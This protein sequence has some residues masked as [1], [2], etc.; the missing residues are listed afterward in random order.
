MVLSM[1]AQAPHTLA[2]AIERP[3]VSTQGAKED[4]SRV[5]PET[6]SGRKRDV[7]R[8]EITDADRLA[9]RFQGYPDLTGE[10]RISP[11]G[12]I[13]IPVI[14]RFNLVNKS[15]AQL[16]KILATKTGEIA[17]REVYVTVETAAYKPMFVTGLVKNPG[18]IQ[19]FP[20][21]TVLQAL[22]LSGGIYRADSIAKSDPAHGLNALS[23]LKKA[24]E[25]EKRSIAVLARVRAEQRGSSV[26][27]VPEHLVK[28]AGTKE[29]EQLIKAQ[30]VLLESRKNSLAGQLASLERGRALAS[31]ELAGLKAQSVR[32]K[33]LLTLRTD[34]R[35]KMQDLLAKGLVRTDRAVDE[36]IKVSELEEKSTNTAVAIARVQATVANL[37]REAV[38]L[39]A[40]R[41]A[42]LEDEALKLEREI[43]Q[44]E[45]ECQTSRDAYSELTGDTTPGGLEKQVTFRLVRDI[46]GA[47]RVISADESV[48]IEPGDVLIVAREP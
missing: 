34:T 45:I 7:R 30:T 10:Y 9:I 33:E 20:G 22:S 16:E 37:E 48:F 36:E 38:T 32:L 41:N 28:V 47:Q 17:G 3:E 11:D 21:M 4:N 8:S 19:W 46:E 29:A 1:L 23:R 5:P 26:I 13:S 25:D 6:G 2:A 39:D 40:E 35:Q 44:L 18:S 27:E 43:A 42:H 24:L 31:Q 14:G 12:T 15:A